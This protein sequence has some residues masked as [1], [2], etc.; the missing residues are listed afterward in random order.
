MNKLGNNNIPSPKTIGDD[1]LLST[2]TEDVFE[3]IKNRYICTLPD[4]WSFDLGSKK[5]HFEDIR[6]EM[7]RNGILSEEIDKIYGENSSIETDGNIIYLVIYN[8][9]EILKKPLFLGEMKK[10]GTND[11]R[12]SE[13]KGKQAQGNAAGDRVAKNY[14]IAA[15]YCYMADK[16]FFPYNV[17]LHGCDFSEHEITKTTR[18][19]L[20]PFFGTL[21][22]FNPW[23]NT[24]LWWKRSGGTCLFQGTNWTYEQLYD[25]CYRCCEE[26]IKHYLKKY[27]LVV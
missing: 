10:Q 17:F 18:A 14:T 6:K 15:D 9:G 27:G 8:N 11:K 26:G 7:I 3:A 12:I 25:I 4:T 2:V 5:I 24:H 1:A 23:F 20:A 16:N 19:K 21:N 22:S 13:G